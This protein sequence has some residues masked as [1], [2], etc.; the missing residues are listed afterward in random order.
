M[1]E[2]AFKLHSFI[3][4]YEPPAQALDLLQFISTKGNCVQ[5]SCPG[6]GKQDMRR[7][8]SKVIPVSVWHWALVVDVV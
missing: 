6:S 5:L 2:K 7:T 3:M 1:C 4:T 8:L